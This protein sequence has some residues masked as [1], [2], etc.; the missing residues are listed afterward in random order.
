MKQK[1][2]SFGPVRRSSPSRAKAAA[3]GRRRRRRRT[4][5]QTLN[6]IL[7]MLVALSIFSVL[8]LTVFFKIEAVE[9]SGNAMYA[10][11]ELIE[12]SGVQIGDNLFRVSVKKVEE[13]LIEKFPYV[14]EVHFKRVFPAKL[15][16]EITQATPLGAVDTS[17]G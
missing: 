9:V 2:L 14:E 15:V 12:S 7:L 11:E 17:V 16:L 4:G 6:Y 13:R 5:R 1:I 3:S 8:S 10:D